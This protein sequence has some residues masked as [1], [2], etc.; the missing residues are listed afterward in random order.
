ME[1][2][3]F[4]IWLSNRMEFSDEDK[5]E[6]FEIARTIVQIATDVRKFGLLSLDDKISSMNDK[7]LQKA[8]QYAV[9]STEAETLRKILQLHIMLNNYKGK[10]LL[11][12]VLI[13]DGINCIINGENPRQIGEYLSMYFG[14]ELSEEFKG[15][16]DKQ[17]NIDRFWDEIKYKKPLHEDTKLDKVITKMDNF[18]VQ[19]IIR[20]I[21]M[22]DLLLA[23]KGLSED[24]IKHFS[25]NMSKR[26]TEVIIEDYLNLIAVKATDVEEAQDRILAKI[27]ELVER[28]ALVVADDFFD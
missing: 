1:N 8:V 13:K 22:K 7:L 23:Y 10:D 9:D 18:A 6:C 2:I 17:Q 5:R 24:A 12:S 25:G 4:D 11:R 27:K 20:N 28:G 21:E 3:A 16:V 15:F 14:D 26:V 19:I